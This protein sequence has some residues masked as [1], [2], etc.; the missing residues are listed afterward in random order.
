M[1][2]IDAYSELFSIDKTIAVFILLTRAFLCPEFRIVI[3]VGGK[4][5]NIHVLLEKCIKLFKVGTKDDLLCRYTKLYSIKK[6]MLC[7]FLKQHFQ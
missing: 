5:G 6:S 1:G 2:K 7:N 3:S 4:Q